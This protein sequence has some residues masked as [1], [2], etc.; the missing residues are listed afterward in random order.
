MVKF[1]CLLKNQENP[2]WLSEHIKSNCIELCLCASQYRKPCRRALSIKHPEF[3]NVEFLSLEIK[4]S[5]ISLREKHWSVQAC[6][7]EATRTSLLTDHSPRGK[8]CFT[9][10]GKEDLTPKP[11]KGIVNFHKRS[12]G[13]LVSIKLI[14]SRYTI[15]LHSGRRALHVLIWALAHLLVPS[16][17]LWDTNIYILFPHS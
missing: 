5:A 2:S 12:W 9:G 15:Q 3:S 7:K 8:L 13:Q 6:W 17:M 10:F 14:G 4:I 11:G 16:Y 1:F